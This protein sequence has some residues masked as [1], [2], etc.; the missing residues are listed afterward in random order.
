MSVTARISTGRGSYT[1]IASVELIATSRR[2]AT[3]VVM[4]TNNIPRQMPVM[5]FRW[6]VQVLMCGGFCGGCV[7]LMRNFSCWEWRSCGVVGERCDW[8]CVDCFIMKDVPIT[9]E[10]A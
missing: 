3:P 9:A 4:A 2:M 6:A 5:P 10:A 1:N 8:P 7:R